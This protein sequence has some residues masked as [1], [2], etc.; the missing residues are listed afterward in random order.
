MSA[1]CFYMDGLWVTAVADAAKAV[2]SPPR[3]ARHRA[4]SHGASLLVAQDVVSDPT[5]HEKTCQCNGI[6]GQFSTAPTPKLV[7]ESFARINADRSIVSRW[8]VTSVWRT[9]HHRYLRRSQQVD[10]SCADIECDVFPP[11]T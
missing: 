3:I 7:C 6:G 2:Q 5:F 4:P 10:E 11:A 8:P 9:I 1:P